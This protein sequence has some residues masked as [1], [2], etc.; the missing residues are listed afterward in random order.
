VLRYATS[1]IPAKK[2]ILG[3]GL[4]GYDWVGQQGQNILWQQ[5][6]ALARSPGVTAGWDAPSSSPHL[7]YDRDGWTPIGAL[8][9]A[10]ERSHRRRPV[11]RAAAAGSARIR[12]SASARP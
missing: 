4:Y 6:D 8:R 9:W 10:T 7:R 1:A 2:L 11:P 12:N 3:V 5:A